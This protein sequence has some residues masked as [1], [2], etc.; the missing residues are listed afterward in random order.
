MWI[1]L[2]PRFWRDIIFATQASIKSHF[3][4]PKLIA[5]QE[6]NAKS[7]LAFGLNDKSWWFSI[8]ALFLLLSI[9]C[10]SIKCCHIEPKI[11]HYFPSKTY[12]TSFGSLKWVACVHLI[13]LAVS[14]VNLISALWHILSHLT[15]GEFIKFLVGGRKWNTQL[16]T[17]LISEFKWLWFQWFTCMKNRIFVELLHRVRASAK[18][19]ASL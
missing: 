17:F 6:F 7:L 9:A 1:L 11:S 10:N 8:C 15:L 16:G 14:L 2:A 12:H 13:Q 18:R 19:A 5:F 3:V 4:T